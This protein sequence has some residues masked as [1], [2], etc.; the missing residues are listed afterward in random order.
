MSGRNRRL[1]EVTEQ[2]NQAIKSFLDANSLNMI[3]D[4][5]VWLSS[6]KRKIII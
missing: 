4:L 3:I 1:L 5:V 6:V 2:L